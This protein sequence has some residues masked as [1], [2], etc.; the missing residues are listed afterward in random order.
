MGT[1]QGKFDIKSVTANPVP[2]I[3]DSSVVD[4]IMAVASSKQGQTIAS[5]LE[6]AEMNDTE[7]LEE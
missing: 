1:L 2:I 4:T 6:D 7:G 5:N 3:A